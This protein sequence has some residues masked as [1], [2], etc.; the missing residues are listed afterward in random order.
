MTDAQLLHKITGTMLPES[1]KSAIRKCAARKLGE[2]R[3]LRSILGVAERAGADP[4]VVA[5]AFGY[6]PILGAPD[7]YVDVVKTGPDDFD[8]A[9][10]PEVPAVWA[11]FALFRLVQRGSQICPIAC[12]SR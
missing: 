5:A 6:L 3:A 2:A 7:Q 12:V 10:L 11:A 1:A 9:E 8:T 4:R